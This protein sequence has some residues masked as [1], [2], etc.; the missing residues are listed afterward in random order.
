LLRRM[1][2]HN[3]TAIA[4]VIVATLFLGLGLVGWRVV[5]NVIAGKRVAS[6]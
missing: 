6:S 5:A 4:F 3:G 1:V 2:F